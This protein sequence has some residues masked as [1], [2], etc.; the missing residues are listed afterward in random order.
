MQDVGTSQAFVKR[1]AA[2]VLYLLLLEVADHLFSS[3]EVVVKQEEHG[4]VRIDAC[5]LEFGDL[6]SDR[7][8]PFDHLFNDRHLDLMAVCAHFGEPTIEDRRP[9]SELGIVETGRDCF[10][11]FG[12]D[13]GLGP[14]QPLVGIDQDLKYLSCEVPEGFGFRQPAQRQVLVAH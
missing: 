12:D 7:V 3:G 1:F 4:G 9:P 14:C 6:S 5:P 8:S 10:A 2:P 13:V 11:F